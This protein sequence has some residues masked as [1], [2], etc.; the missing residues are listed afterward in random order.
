MMM[1]L[2]LIIYINFIQKERYNKLYYTLFGA[3]MLNFD[4]IASQQ[5]QVDWTMGSPGGTEDLGIPEQYNEIGSSICNPIMQAALLEKEGTEFNIVMGLCV[6]HDSV[7]YKYSAAPVTTL[8]CKDRV[9]CHNPVSVLYNA[10]SF[11]Q[12]KLFGDK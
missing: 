4:A 3:T 1:P 11:Y 7:F 12:K 2:S 8:V 9:T 5:D 6:G 10:E